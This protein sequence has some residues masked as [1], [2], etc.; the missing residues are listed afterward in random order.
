MFDWIRAFDDLLFLKPPS[1][2]YAPLVFHYL[3]VAAVPV[4]NPWLFS[5]RSTRSMDTFMVHYFRIKAL[6]VT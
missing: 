3:S 5:G 1:V 2:R 4:F 6:L